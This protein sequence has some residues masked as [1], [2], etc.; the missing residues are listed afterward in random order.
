MRLCEWSQQEPEIFFFF[1]VKIL[2]IYVKLF[3]LPCMLGGYNE[4]S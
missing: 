2:E 4:D 1:N 3:I